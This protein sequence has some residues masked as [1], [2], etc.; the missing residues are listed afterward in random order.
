[1]RSLVFCRFLLLGLTASLV[2]ACEPEARLAPSDQVAAGRSGRRAHAARC[3]RPGGAGVP[4]IAVSRA[5]DGRGRRGPR[6]QRLLARYG[7][8]VFETD[9]MT[10]ALEDL[11]VRAGHGVV[12]AP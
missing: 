12:P 3:A 9:E 1:M 10:Q 8:C 7:H 6:V 2:D 4:R 5:G 11:V